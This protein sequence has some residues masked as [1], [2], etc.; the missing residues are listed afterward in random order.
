[1]KTDYVFLCGVMWTQF[2]LQDAGRELVRA[3]DSND[4]DI[5]LLASALLASTSEHS[6]RIQ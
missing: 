5:A 3:L 4:P 1:M 6:G 2:G